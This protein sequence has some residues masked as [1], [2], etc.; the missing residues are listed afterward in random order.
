MQS[1]RG[2]L[3]AFATELEQ[4]KKDFQDS[5][6]ATHSSALEEVEQE[7]EIEHE[8]ENIREPERPFHF[9]ALSI[10]RLHED[11]QEFAK[12]GKV[13]A[14]SEA[15]RPMLAVL[16]C[17]ASGR[18][19]GAFAQVKSPGLYVSKQFSRTVR[20]TEPNDNFIRPCQWILWSTASNK[21][22]VVSPEEA[23][24][25]LPYLRQRRQPAGASRTHLIVYSAPVTRRMLHFN[26]LSYHATPPLL[27]DTKVPLW[28][29][30]E[31]GIFAGRL[32]FEWHEY[33]ELLSYLG[34]QTIV[35]EDEDY[36]GNSS[37]D[38]FVQKPLTF[39]KSCIGS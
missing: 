33:K 7:R 4:R 26:D 17:T 11:I 37:R 13:V 32:Y 35:G 25:L 30:V 6:I 23:D 5:G 27:P 19:H 38:T 31:L 28:L 3:G 2:A 12:S 21:A 18:R 20:V 34:V 10:P 8:V 36:L 1:Y 22:L 14:G 29:K 15:Y 16:Q 39:R 24:A 9:T